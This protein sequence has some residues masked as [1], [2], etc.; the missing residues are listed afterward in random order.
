MQ[1][2][3]YCLVWIV[4]SLLFLSWLRAKNNKQRKVVLRSKSSSFLLM[5]FLNLSY[6]SKVYWTNRSFYRV[7]PRPEVERDIPFHFMFE[8]GRTQIQMDLP[9]RR[10]LAVPST[11]YEC[12][13]RTSKN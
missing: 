9:G 1:V 8:A 5:I 7:A 3:I 13:P 11:A 6:R 2:F 10:V 12:V 4:H